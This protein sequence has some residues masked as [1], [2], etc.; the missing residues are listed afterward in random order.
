[1]KPINGKH[2][3]LAIRE[4]NTESNHFRGRCG[5]VRRASVIGAPSAIISGVSIDRIMCCTM[6][7]LI[8]TVS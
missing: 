3:T 4:C 1:M 2:S 8:R 6:C 7:T 5:S